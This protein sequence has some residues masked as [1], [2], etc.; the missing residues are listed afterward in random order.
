M[1]CNLLCEKEWY[2]FRVSIQ[3]F[4]NVVE[5]HP[6]SPMNPGLSSIFIHDSWKAWLGDHHHRMTL[7][8]R[9]MNNYWIIESW[10]GLNGGWSG[11]MD[12]YERHYYFFCC[13]AECNDGKPMNKILFSA[14][15]LNIKNIEFIG[16]SLLFCI[17]KK[18]SIQYADIFL[19]SFA[20]SGRINSRSNSPPTL[21]IFVAVVMTSWTKYL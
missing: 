13:F 21:I 7:G 5:H 8:V 20:K 18:Y 1:M 12:F 16:F 9:V 15:D 6:W 2:F 4:S 19:P 10:I 11:M 3:I 14:W 17:E